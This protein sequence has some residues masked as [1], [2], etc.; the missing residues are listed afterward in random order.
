M[1]SESGTRSKI[2]HFVSAVSSTVSKRTF[3]ASTFLTFTYQVVCNKEYMRCLT[4][5]FAYELNWYTAKI[6]N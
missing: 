3:F 5:L 6:N 1:K 2:T 4:Y